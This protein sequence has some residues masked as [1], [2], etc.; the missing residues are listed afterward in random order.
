MLT[1]NKN[2]NNKT[3]N[4]ACPRSRQE[5]DNN[6]NKGN[7]MKKDQQKQQQLFVPL[8]SGAES[9]RSSAHTQTHTY[10]CT[11]TGNA[12]ERVG[13]REASHRSSARRRRR[14]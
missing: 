13:E 14:N 6:N 10:A 5:E 12:C 11:C 1:A 4:N 8:S 7:N 2:N 3:N 9:R